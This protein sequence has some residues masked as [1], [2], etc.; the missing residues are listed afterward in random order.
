MQRYLRVI[1]DNLLSLSS[2]SVGDGRI[3]DAV[4]GGVIACQWEMASAT[5]SHPSISSVKEMFSMK[6]T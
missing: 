6:L 2:S 5:Q 1:S 4:L 3:Y